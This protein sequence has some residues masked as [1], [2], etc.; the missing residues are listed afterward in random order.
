[1]AKKQESAKAVERVYNV[2]LRKEY[3]KVPNWRRTKKAVVAMKEFLARHMKS[4][5]VRLGKD[6]NEKI[7][8]HGIRNPPHHVKVTV[9]KDE[10]GVVHAELFG[11][12]K[13][14]EHAVSKKEAATVA[15]AKEQ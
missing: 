5:D 2:P 3:Q 12:K 7:W 10:K 1:M 11:T 15:E 6:V 8:Q 14:S 13:T 9:R 4:E